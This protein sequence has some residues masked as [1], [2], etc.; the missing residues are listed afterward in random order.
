MNEA[1]IAVIGSLGGVVVGGT[2][3]YFGDRLRLDREDLRRAAQQT[4]E[5]EERWRQACVHLATSAYRMR[6]LAWSFTDFRLNTDGWRSDPYVQEL[7]DRLETAYSDCARCYNELRVMGLL[8]FEE[9]ADK[10]LEKAEDV[11]D[12]AFA[13]D[14]DYPD[15][16]LGEVLGAFLDAVHDE[17][18]L[19]RPA[20][21]TGGPNRSHG[22]SGRP[23]RA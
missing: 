17:F 22:T 1:W 11:V 5:T 4:S 16:S 6:S 2:V 19:E 7:Q 18:G 13:E 3:T 14:P 21:R 9:E 10:L 8:S 20:S 12:R 15:D 23:T